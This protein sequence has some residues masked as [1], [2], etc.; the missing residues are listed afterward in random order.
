MNGPDRWQSRDLTGNEW[1]RQVVEKRPVRQC[2]RPDR[3]Q[4]RDLSD[5]A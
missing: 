4:S 5:N 3:W 2:I 1:T